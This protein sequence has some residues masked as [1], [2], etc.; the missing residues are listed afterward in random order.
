MPEVEVRLGA[1][2]GDEHLAVL[3]RRHRPR[4]DV[5]VR[6]ELLQLDVEPAGHQEATDRGGGDSLAERG[7]HPAR[8]EDEPGFA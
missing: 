4:I 5:D 1:V 7:H 8:D 2:L 3:V 6:V